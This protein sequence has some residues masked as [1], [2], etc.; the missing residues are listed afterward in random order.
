VSSQ[1][2][3]TSVELV[4]RTADGQ[5]RRFDINGDGHHV[6]VD[7][8]LD[9]AEGDVSLFALGEP[10][11]SHSPRRFVATVTADGAWGPEPLLT[12]HVGL[13]RPSELA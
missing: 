8:Q 9:D 1:P 2:K 13:L 5:V 3:V 4:V 11:R 12:L 7:A 6:K 10:Q